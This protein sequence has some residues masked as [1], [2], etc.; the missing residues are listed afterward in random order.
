MKTSSTH[1]LITATIL[2]ALALPVTAGLFQPKGDTLEEK[3]AKVRKD[4][5][6]ILAKLYET[7][8]EAKEKIKKAAGYATF[9]NVN[10]NLLL[11]S[12]GHGYGMVVDTKTKKETFMAMGSLGGGLG[13]GAKDLRAVFIFQNAEVMKEFVDSGW[14]F[15]GE[16]DA[17]AK[18][19]D[20]GLGSTAKEAGVDTGGHVF[21]IYQMT[22][23]GVSLQATIAGT[24][25]W[26]DTK[27]NE[28]TTAKTTPEK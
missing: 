28:Q 14:Q 13:L 11:L 20:K 23:S 10:I 8:P 4:R 5:D 15:G 19:G 25:Y 22:E 1:I 6:E 18:S 27:L 12:S 24:K 7:H 2:C 17:T 26:R 16:A 9:N 21:E 3:R